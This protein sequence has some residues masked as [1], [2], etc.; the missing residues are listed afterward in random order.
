MLRHRR[1]HW[2]VL[3]TD[4]TWL[5]DTVVKNQPAKKKKKRIN[6]QCRRHVGD[7]G[8]V[9]GLG[10]FPWRRKWQPTPGF[11]PGESHGQ[12]S[13]WGYSPWGCK[14][15]D[16]TKG[17]P[18]LLPVS[19]RC[20]WHAGSSCSVT[21]LCLTPC[22][23]MDCS[24]PGSSDYGIFQAGLLEWVAI[25]SSRRSAWPRDRTSVSCVSSMLQADSLQLSHWERPITDIQ[26]YTFKVYNIMVWLTC[27]VS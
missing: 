5:G 10:R 11:L 20:N 27:T 26:H 25:S 2:R 4:V 19:L 21:W 1:N 22:D 6:L 24:P 12:R 7:A 18:F 8:S 23:P 16:T 15:S 13:L 9:L 3:R 17:L 14:E